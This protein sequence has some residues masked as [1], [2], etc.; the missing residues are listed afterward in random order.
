M[1]PHKSSLIFFLEGQVVPSFRVRWGLEC[2][3]DE[4]GTYCCSITQYVTKAGLEL[5]LTLLPGF[6]MPGLQVCV[7]LVPFLYTVY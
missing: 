2:G 4:K 7:S 5:A 3:E 1:S 6:Q